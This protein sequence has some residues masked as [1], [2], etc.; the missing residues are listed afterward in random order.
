[1]L[2][3]T[4]PCGMLDHRL[5][6]LE[7]SVSASVAITRIPSLV[8]I[9]AVLQEMIDNIVI[10]EHLFIPGGISSKIITSKLCHN[11]R[12]ISNDIDNKILGKHWYQTSS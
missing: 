2:L 4:G 1:M 11:V 6:L 8:N 10:G 12:L 9:L 3:I 5:H 7:G